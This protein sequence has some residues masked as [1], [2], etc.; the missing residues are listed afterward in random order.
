MSFRSLHRHLERCNRAR[1]VVGTACNCPWRMGSL[2]KFALKRHW[3]WDKIVFSFAEG[4]FVPSSVVAGDRC[5]RRFDFGSHTGTSHHLTVLR[6][7]PCP[8]VV[9]AALADPSRHGIIHLRV[10]HFGFTHLRLGTSR[11]MSGFRIFIMEQR[12]VIKIFVGL[13]RDD[14]SRFGCDHCTFVACDTDGDVLQN[15]TKQLPVRFSAFLFTIL[16][17]E[18]KKLTAAL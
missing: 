5:T 11:I 18:K 1:I 3:F 12:V 7:R 16:K 13:D 14:D 8:S 15:K 10:T 17:A 2:S 4:C 6:S 9:N